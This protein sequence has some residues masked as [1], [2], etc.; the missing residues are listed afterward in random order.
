M[1]ASSTSEIRESLLRRAE[2]LAWVPVGCSGNV[3][4]TEARWRTTVAHAFPMELE[5]LAGQ[6]AAHEAARP[7][8]LSESRSALDP[9]P[10]M[11]DAELAAQQAE[12]AEIAREVARERARQDEA[13]RQKILADHGII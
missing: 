13:L 4:G 10:M 5:Q 2:A 8:R 9:L 12:R 11:D 6:L 3:V 1:N 7:D